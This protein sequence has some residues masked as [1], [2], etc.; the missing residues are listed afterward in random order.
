LLLTLIAGS[1]LQPSLLIKGSF[2]SLGEEKQPLR[3]RERLVWM[4]SFI[5]QNPILVKVEFT[6]F[7]VANCIVVL[8]CVASLQVEALSLLSSLLMCCEQTIHTCCPSWLQ[9]VHLTYM[10]FIENASSIQ[11]TSN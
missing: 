5:P 6:A 7:Q 1:N 3:N 9:G 11:I 8:F 4:K 2:Q 10:T